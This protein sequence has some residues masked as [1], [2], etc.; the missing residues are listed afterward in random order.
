VRIPT[1]SD[2][3]FMNEHGEP[4]VAIPVDPD[5]DNTTDVDLDAPLPLALTPAGEA[6]LLEYENAPRVFDV[7]L[8]PE[9]VKALDRVEVAHALAR[10]VRPGLSLGDFVAEVRR[11]VA[12]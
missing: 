1:C 6:A 8:T 2:E 5:W 3:E 9:L 12:W 11:A 7:A 10:L 4:A